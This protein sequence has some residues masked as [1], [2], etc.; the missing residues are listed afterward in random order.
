MLTPDHH[1]AAC[2]FQLSIGAVTLSCQQASS[3]RRSTPRRP[4]AP[5]TCPAQQPASPMTVA[6]DAAG[7][8]WLAFITKPSHDDL[9]PNSLSAEHTEMETPTTAPQPPATPTAGKHRY[10][11]HD[12]L[13]VL[14][15]MSSKTLTSRMDVRTCAAVSDD[16]QASLQGLQTL[17]QVCMQ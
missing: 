6:A 4:P 10:S 9:S 17:I 8:S 3:A 5:A 16:P 14:S 1:H 13:C 15:Q 7:L 2:K 11:F 12:C